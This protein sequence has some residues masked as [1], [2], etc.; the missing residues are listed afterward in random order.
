MNLA[1][2]Q[3]KKGEKNMRIISINLSGQSIPVYNDA[4]TSNPTQ[5]ATILNRELWVENGYDG[6]S[7]ST[8]VSLWGPGNKFVNGYLRAWQSPPASAYERA[9]AGKYAYG[10]YGSGYKFKVAHRQSRIFS[11]TNVIHAVQPGGYIVTDGYSNGGQDFNY[12]LS[13][14]GYFDNGSTA[15]HPVSNGWCDTDI[16]IGCDMYNTA[17]ID[18]NW[19]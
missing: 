16:E 3:K 9:Y 13:I 14:L 19:V 6:E 18:G 12:R 4:Y 7:G 5:I 1:G 15:Y 11:G 17:T 8:S 2:N 10:T